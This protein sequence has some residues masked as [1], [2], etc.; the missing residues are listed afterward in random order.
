MCRIVRSGVL[1]NPTKE[2]GRALFRDDPIHHHHRTWHLGIFDIAIRHAKSPWPPFLDFSP[3]TR[4]TGTEWQH[5]V[6]SS[7]NMGGMQSVSIAHATAC[8]ASE[9]LPVRSRRH[10]ANLLGRYEQTC[11]YQ[12]HEHFTNRTYTWDHCSFKSR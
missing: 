2:S 5:H 1:H 4:C 6:S 9:R 12:D 8:G 3:S 11:Y 10:P 7:T